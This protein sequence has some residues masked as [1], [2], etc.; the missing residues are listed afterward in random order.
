MERHI[1]AHLKSKS[2]SIPSR[3][4][5]IILGDSWSAVADG[6]LACYYN[7]VVESQMGLVSVSSEMEFS[8]EREK[9]QIATHC[10]EE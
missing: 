2:L 9:G 10:N 5:A 6:Q 7:F 4:L 8:F 3:Y 1:R